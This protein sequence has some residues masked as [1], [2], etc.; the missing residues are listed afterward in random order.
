LYWKIGQMIHREI[1]KE[2]RV[3]YGEQIIKQLAEQLTINYGRGFN[4]RALFR[5]GGPSATR[6][7]DQRI[8]SP[9]L[10]QLS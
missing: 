8:K 4:A 3:E 7:R 1:L 2:E 9:L 10:Y 5:I 6:T